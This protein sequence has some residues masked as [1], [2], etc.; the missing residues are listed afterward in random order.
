MSIWLPSS[1]VLK[2]RGLHLYR[3]K[4]QI[5]I[6]NGIFIRIHHR[7]KATQGELEDTNGIIW[8]HKWKEQ[9]I[10]ESRQNTQNYNDAKYT[11]QHKS[12]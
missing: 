1:A 6:L 9:T 11:T 2:F 5:T 4:K 10:P 12:H 3:N 7:S 8:S